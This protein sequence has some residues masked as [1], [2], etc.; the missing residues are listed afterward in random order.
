MYVKKATSML[1][2]I[3]KGGRGGPG[4]LGG[5]RECG[6]A[7]EEDWATFPPPNLFYNSTKANKFGTKKLQFQRGEGEISIR[8]GRNIN[9][10]P[11]N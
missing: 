5:L 10:L 4:A 11:G 9:L 8:C 7:A 3:K 1:S 2:R 6:E